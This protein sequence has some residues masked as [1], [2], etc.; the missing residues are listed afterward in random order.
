ME[1][2]KD[3]DVDMVVDMII[4]NR[5]FNRYIFNSSIGIVDMHHVNA[6]LTCS[7]IRHG[8]AVP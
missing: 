2:E 4:V 5:I 8:H 7:I 3:M 6:A 1:I